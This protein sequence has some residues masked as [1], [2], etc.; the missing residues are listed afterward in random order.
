MRKLITNGRKVLNN[1]PENLPFFFLKKRMNF[2]NQSIITNVLGGNNYDPLSTLLFNF[3]LRDILDT[4]EGWHSGET[5]A[6][7]VRC[8]P[9]TFADDLIFLDDNNSEMLFILQAVERFLHKRGVG[10]N[11]GKYCTRQ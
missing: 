11:V 8:L 4:F 6:P 2:E 7:G 1:L 9:L 5:V 10:I 3:V